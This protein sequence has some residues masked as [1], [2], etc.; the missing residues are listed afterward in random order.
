LFHVS[1]NVLIPRPETE[2]LIDVVKAWSV[3]HRPQ[4]QSLQCWDVGT[5]S[6]CM[7][8]SLALEIPHLHLTASDISTDAL[9]VATQNAQKWAVLERVKLLPSDVLRE[10]LAGSWD[11]IISN[12]PY[13]ATEEMVD[14][15]PEVQKEPRLALDGGADGL[16]FYR[17]LAEIASNSLTELGLLAVEIGE[18]QGAAVEK[19]FREAG[20]AEIHI[21]K[22]LAGLDRV[23]TTIKNQA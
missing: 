7:A 15:M 10:A 22:D 13:I 1:E 23:V 3:K 8:V 18:G 14:L 19:I 11:M 21:K 6:G 17:R 4:S 9:R 5:G 16:S 20:F 2:D 12:P